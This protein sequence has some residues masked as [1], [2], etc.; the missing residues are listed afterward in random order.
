MGGCPRLGHDSALR[1]LPITAVVCG[2]VGC[3]N[4][5]SWHAQQQEQ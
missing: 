4:I 3:F 1:F 5:P 2:K